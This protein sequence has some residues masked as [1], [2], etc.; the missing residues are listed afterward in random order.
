MRCLLST[1]V[2]LFL[3][4]WIFAFT[5]E[6]ELYSLAESRYFAKNYSV[7]ME[8][9]DE[10][11][12]TFPLSS[13]VPDVQYRRA[14]C[15]YRLGQYQDSLTLLKRIETRYRATRYLDYLPFWAGL[16]FY[17]LKDYGSA[18]NSFES[19]L[20]KSEKGESTA[21]ALFYKGLSEIY[22]ENYGDGEATLQIVM[23]E[24]K[25]QIITSSALVLL[26][27]IY[28][29][30]EKYESILS[31]TQNPDLPVLP[32]TEKTKLDF[33]RAE[34]LF[35][36]NR[37]DEAKILYRELTGASTEIASSAFQ[38]LFLAAQKEGN[39]GEMEKLLGIAEEK[40]SGSYEFL[41]DF[42]LHIGIE[43][44]K[45]NNPG[46]AEHFFLKIW[47]IREKEEIKESVPLYLSE[48]YI[49]QKNYQKAWDILSGY[50]H[51]K[52]GAPDNGYP[53]DFILR[54]GDISLMLNDYKQAALYY[55]EFLDSNPRNPRKPDAE[56]YLAY[57]LYRQGDTGNALLLTKGV[58]ESSI[59][60]PYHRDFLKLQIL[61]YRKSGRTQDTLAV[62]KQFIV[63]YPDDIRARVD[64]LKMYFTLKIYDSVIDEVRE[65]DRKIPQL[66]EKDNRSFLLSRYLCGLS[67][68]VK[69]EYADAGAYLSLIQV[70]EAEKAGL[71]LIA[72]YSLFYHAWSLYRLGK[73][74]QATNLFSV[75]IRDF[76]THALK[77]DALYLAGWCSYSGGNYEKAV[78]YF[79]TLAGLNTDASIKAKALFFQ[80]RSLLNLKKTDEAK[81][82]FKL[83]YN[84]MQKTA[85]ADDALFE[86]ATILA[87]QDETE[88]AA[89]AYLTLSQVYPGSTLVEDALYRR[90]EVYFLAKL[91][92]K[93]RY[94]FYEYRLKY[95]NGTLIDAALYWGG[96]CSFHLSEKFGAVLLWEKIIKEYRESAYRPNA[97]KKTAEVY[98]ES[99]EYSKALSLYSELIS[100]YPREAS[101]VNAEA[102]LEELR[103]KI[104]GLSDREAEL[105]VM[106]ER[107]KGARTHEGREA[108]LSLATLY[109]YEQEKGKQDLAYTLLKQVVEKTE[110]PDT[111]SRAQFLIGEYFYIKEDFI[112]AGNEFLKAAL[113]DPKNRDLM[114]FSLYK[115]AEMMKL[116][117]KPQEV[118]DL[119]ER[120]KKNF[121]QSQWAEEGKRLLEGLE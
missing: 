82:I 95:P 72:P 4:A 21:Q 119:V 53:A 45:Q 115:A 32:E 83:I 19:F 120:L 44:Y 73:F 39:F 6:S 92:E 36:L 23:K 112:K 111:A 107:N 31:L 103:Y 29:K 2:L 42:W 27:F 64:L 14:V 9:Y 87:D 74:E 58:L 100:A 10:F 46:L 60:G 93:A 65:L 16:N 62:L 96:L 114:A 59:T 41:T 99:G 15:M 91:Y 78:T 3:S 52:S 77:T 70:K 34:A 69:K 66:K 118:R 47:N 12:K 79:S 28:L 17:Y 56:Y 85:F 110:D 98:A 106:I 1:F 11:V 81:E 43:Y 8:T 38:R 97:M 50:I 88:T 121:P 54:L 35:H 25:D 26:A 109:L 116:A 33:Y 63:L 67:F 5:T 71:S 90:G 13:L 22:L 113:I 7:A 18:V 57:S 86:Y 80:A 49:K 40:F 108:L 55:R 75:I 48:I 68:I 101:A 61:L 102:S 37:L 104:L 51:E 76:T 105:T 84:K 20:K 30:Q 24:Y 89:S 94:A 117:G